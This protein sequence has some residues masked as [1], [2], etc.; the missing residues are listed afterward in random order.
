LVV[1]ANLGDWASSGCAVRIVN[2]THG[3]I[4]MNML[5]ARSMRLDV[6]YAL[7]LPIGSRFKLYCLLVAIA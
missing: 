6:T 4:G 5:Q 1:Q 2:Y 7:Q 3:A